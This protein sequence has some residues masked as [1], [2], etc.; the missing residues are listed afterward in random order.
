MNKK[1]LVVDDSEIV[2]AMATEALV[3]KSYEVWT[4]LS[5][6]AA[7]RFI[8]SA[9]RPDVIIMDVMMPML[10]GDKKTRILKSEVSTRDI[11]V[12]L[13]SSKPESELARLVAEC[14]ADGYI[15]KPFTYRELIDSIEAVFAEK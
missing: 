1:V 5:A 6:S 12:L 14:G 9:E 8:Y 4:S 7:D 13:L 3:T 2:L 15:R 10:D 11:P